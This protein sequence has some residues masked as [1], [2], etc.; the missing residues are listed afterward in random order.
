MATAITNPTP[1]MIGKPKLRRIAKGF[2]YEVEFLYVGT[3]AQHDAAI[4]ALGGLTSTSLTV[5]DGVSTETLSGNQTTA[6]A[7]W[8]AGLSFLQRKTTTTNPDGTQSTTGVESQILSVDS[9][10]LGGTGD[11]S[12]W[13]WRVTFQSGEDNRGGGGSVPTP[14]NLSKKIEANYN[15]KELYLDPI[16]WGI[17]KAEKDDTG[18]TPYKS[19]AVKVAGVNTTIEFYRKYKNIKGNY[20]K[21]GDFIY[22]NAYPKI[23]KKSTVV[24]TGVETTTQLNST[25]DYSAESTGTVNAYLSPYGSGGNTSSDSWTVTQGPTSSNV[26]FAGQKCKVL[27][28][29]VTFYRKGKKAGGKSCEW[30]GINPGTA[31]ENPADGASSTDI[32][33]FYTEK[34]LWKAL[35][36]KV[37]EIRDTQGNIWAKITRTMESAPKNASIQ[38]IWNKLKSFH[39]EW[40]W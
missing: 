14:E 35:D 32:D 19:D 21:V 36:C 29:S 26:D 9:D 4:P 10:W 8:L 24:D 5:T 18:D 3:Q 6:V 12:S 38:W 17:R 28:Y 40:T 37:D 22:K 20:C 7:S 39:G 13:L 16:W 33:P 23:W 34:Y 27:V 11:K 1:T 30:R 25:G 31:F 15:T 2:V